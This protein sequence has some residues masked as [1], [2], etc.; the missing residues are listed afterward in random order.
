[1]TTASKETGVLQP[2]KRVFLVDDHE[3]VRAGLITLINAECDLVVCGE[4]EDDT[5]ALAAIKELQPDVAIVD[6]SLKGRDASTLIRTLCR[7]Q[8]QT[9]VLVLSVHE[10]E[11]Y[12]ERATNAGAR[13]Y[14]MKHEATDKLIKAIRC[15]TTGRALPD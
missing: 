6:W 9:P 4:A 1:M 11:Y 15:M 12:A 7:Q 10:R 8:P 14:I 3:A 2:K 13:G 5:C